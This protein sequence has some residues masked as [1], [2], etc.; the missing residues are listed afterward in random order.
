MLTPDDAEKLTLA[1]MEG[2]ITLTLRNPLD[3]APTVTDGAKLS[4]LLGETQS[5]ACEAGRARPRR[6]ARRAQAGAA[7]GSAEGY[8]VET[9]RAAKRT[10]E[11]VR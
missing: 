10:E 11:E 4:E 6:G 9:I 2:S 3:V 5:S 8:T 7:A 1:S